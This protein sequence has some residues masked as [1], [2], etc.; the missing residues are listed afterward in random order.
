MLGTHARTP[1]LKRGRPKQG[2]IV[3]GAAILGEVGE[4]FPPPHCKI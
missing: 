3:A 1:W 2:D 4:N